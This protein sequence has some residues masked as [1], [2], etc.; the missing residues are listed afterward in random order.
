MKPTTL[1]LALLASYVLPLPAMAA[2]TPGS[3]RP[4]GADNFY[5]SP[6]VTGE[7]VSFHNQYQ[8]DVVG[9]L[10]RPGPA[11]RQPRAR[12]GGW[13][14]NGR[15]EGAELAA[16]R[17]EAGRAGLRYAGDRSSFWGESGGAP[18]HMVAPEIYS[19][20]ISAAVDF[21]STQAFVDPDRIGGPVSVAA[22]AL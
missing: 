18:R 13:P 1:L 15:G 20:D 21:L 9:T 6:T 12:R 17:A 4:A 16:L 11:S 10:Y 22:A 8:M 5:R 7:R 19:D 14:P 3:A 2:D